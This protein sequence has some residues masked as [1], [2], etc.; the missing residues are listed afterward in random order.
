MVG[1]IVGWILIAMKR[2]AL[3]GWAVTFTSVAFTASVFG[4]VSLVVDSH[5]QSDRLL[6]V[7]DRHHDAP[8]VGALGA[9]EPSWVYYLGSPIQVLSADAGSVS[10][11]LPADGSPRPWAPREAVPV[12]DFLQQGPD[13]VVITTEGAFATV[14][15]SLP[16]DCV[17]LGE[18][19]YF[20]KKERLLAIGRKPVRE[21]EIAEQGDALGRKR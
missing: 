20:L 12:L 18:V 6:K 11:R 8:V 15:E 1:G 7:I 13:R 21:V 16:D 4:F 17:V 2:L 5:Q 3:A 14:R 10:D 9:L 19:R